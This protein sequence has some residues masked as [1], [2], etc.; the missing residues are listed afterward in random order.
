MKILRQLWNQKGLD[1]AVED[2]PEDRYGF[3]NIAENISRS[4]L[5]LP[6]EASNVVGIE[7]AWGSGK[8]SLLNLILRNLALK[9]DAHTH[10]LHI[11]PWLSGGSP[12]EA[13]FFRLPR[14]SSRKWKYAIP[15]GLQKALA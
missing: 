3:G 13:S 4:I 11:S 10:V 15:E 8:T 6:L 7:G 12:V 1:A 9:K 2:V 5:T 14:L